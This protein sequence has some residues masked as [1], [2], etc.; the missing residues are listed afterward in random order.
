MKTVK[1]MGALLSVLTITSCNN[2]VFSSSRNFGDFSYNGIFLTEYATKQIGVEE[3]KALVDITPVSQPNRMVKRAGDVED[4]E[5]EVEVVETDNVETVL[6]KY[7]SLV[8]TVKYYISDNEEQQVRKDIYQGTDFKYL[9]D[10]NHYEPFGQMSVKYL[11]VDDVLLDDMEAQN[12]K[13][14]NSRNNLASPFNDPYTYHTN[15]E[16]KLIVQTH[17]FAELPA[18]VGGGIGSTFRQD[19]ELIFDEEGK[20]SFWQS[21]LGIYTSTPTGTIKEGYIFEVD[22]EWVTK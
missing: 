21:S 14:K 20:I 15:E 1:L 6:T 12:K 11:F 16:N 17:S 2:K 8:T 19:C 4:T 10:I 18:S 3:A 7:A 9:L 13:F 22:F 5:A